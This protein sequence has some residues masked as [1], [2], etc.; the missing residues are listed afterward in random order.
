MCYMGI[1]QSYTSS[2]VC[3]VDNDGQVLFTSVIGSD[4]NA[5]EF[6]RAWDVSQAIARVAL[7]YNPSAIAIEGLAFGGRGDAT[8][9]LAGLQF[10]IVSQLMYGLEQCYTVSVVA[11]TS[12]KKFATGSGKAEKS[13]MLEAIPNPI[14]SELEKQ[15]KKTKGLFDVVDAY[16]I[17]QYIRQIRSE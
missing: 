15:Y 4:K 12:L 17:S 13:A 7:D 1:D 10:V 16:H 9:K 2:G 5:C 6:R 11:P 14:R 8:R 3:I